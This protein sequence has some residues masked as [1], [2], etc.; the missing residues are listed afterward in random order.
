MV[1]LLLDN[2]AKVNA[3]D[4]YGW[5]PLHV[6][7]REERIH[8]GAVLDNIVQVRGGREREEVGRGQR[9]REE[10]GGRREEREN[11]GRERGNRPGL[12]RVESPP[13]EGGRRGRGIFFTG[14]FR[15]FSDAGRIFQSKMPT[16]APFWNLLAFLGS[17]STLTF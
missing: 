12:L 14:N 7:M 10:G 13:H 16:G 5:T 15:S 6:T 8:K 3:Q 17:P 11:A 9:R 4:R 1:K 2:G